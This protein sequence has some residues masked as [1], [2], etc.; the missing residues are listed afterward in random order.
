M[1]P[2]IALLWLHLEVSGENVLP[3]GN[4]P[5]KIVAIA[6]HSHINTTRVDVMQRVRKLD[7][8]PHRLRCP[9]L[10]AKPEIW[11]LAFTAPIE[12]AAVRFSMFLKSEPSTL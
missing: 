7:A 5:P 8:S 2:S 1:L 4:Q 12:L 6:F 11:W 10:A 3:L 9:D